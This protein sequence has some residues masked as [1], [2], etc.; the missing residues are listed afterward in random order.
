MVSIVSPTQEVLKSMTQGYATMKGEPK[1]RCLSCP[2]NT[3]E[4]EGGDY[5][6]LDKNKGGGQAARTN[7]LIVMG[8]HRI[9]LIKL[10][11][12]TCKEA[13]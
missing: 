7:R 3:I 11:I 1:R 9:M 13:R 5:R 8:R 12:N 4:T 6:E 2:I 10:A